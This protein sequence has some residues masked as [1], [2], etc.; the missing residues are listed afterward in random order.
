[1]NDIWGLRGDADMADVVAERP[2]A[3]VIVMHNQHDTDYIDLA[4]E[5]CASLRESIVIAQQHGIAAERLVVDPGFGFGKTPAQNLELLRRLGQLR[6]LGRPILAGLS[7]KSTTGLLTDGAPA[8][9]RLE[10]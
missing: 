8:D 5:V 6:A 7:R 4:R 10:G 9:D 1:V 3:G 2:D